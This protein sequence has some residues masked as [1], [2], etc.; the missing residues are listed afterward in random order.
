MIGDVLTHPTR[1]LCNEKQ[2]N[3]RHNT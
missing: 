1:I 2:S 3:T